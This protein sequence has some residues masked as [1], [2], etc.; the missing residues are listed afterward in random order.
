MA[1]AAHVGKLLLG[2]YSARYEDE[3]GLLR[4]AREVFPES[5]LSTEGLTVSVK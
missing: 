2:H 5:Y 4:E 1:R 3:Q